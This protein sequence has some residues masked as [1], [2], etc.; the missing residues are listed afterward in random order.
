MKDD[1]K[2]RQD[3]ATPYVDTRDWKLVSVTPSPACLPALPINPDKVVILP[4][5]PAH[6]IRRAE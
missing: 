1:Q 6:L 4:G 3:L 5:I 2:L